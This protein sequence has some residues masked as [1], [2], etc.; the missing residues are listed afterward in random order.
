MCINFIKRPY[1]SLFRFL[2]NIFQIFGDRV[3]LFRFDSN[4]NQWKE[5]GLGELKILKS[6]GKLR[7]RILMRRE[8]VRDF[9]K[10]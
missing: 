9:F 2:A 10:T 5:R 1:I 6:K 7:F 3:K 4:L 8:Q